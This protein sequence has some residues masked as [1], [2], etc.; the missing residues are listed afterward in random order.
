MKRIT[1]RFDDNIELLDKRSF[2]KLS[3]DETVRKLFT[4]IADYEDC[5]ESKQNGV[6]LAI[7]RQEQWL[8][9]EDNDKP[10][11]MKAAMYWGALNLARE[12]GAI[13]ELSMKS[14]FG[15]YISKQMNLK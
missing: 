12:W 10:L 5:I 8:L 9:S 15:D 3:H 6:M 11:E 7:H 13:D 14:L 4:I 1:K 2:E